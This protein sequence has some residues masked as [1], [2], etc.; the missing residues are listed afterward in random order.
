LAS[1]GLADSRTDRKWSEG[2][3]VEAGNPSASSRTRLGNCRESLSRQPFLRSPW[4]Q[5]AEVQ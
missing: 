2:L 3:C 1:G 5:A 4:T